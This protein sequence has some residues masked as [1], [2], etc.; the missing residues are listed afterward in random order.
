MAISAWA[1]V[2]TWAMDINTESGC[3]RSSDPDVTVGGRINDKP[4]GCLQILLKEANISVP[5]KGISIQ[6]LT[7]LK[8]IFSIVSVL[9]IGIFV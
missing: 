4:R 1:L 9:N 6:K 7:I 8:Y 3:S 2:V 5:V